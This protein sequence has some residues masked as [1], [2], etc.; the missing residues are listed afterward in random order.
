MMPITVILK[1]AMGGLLILLIASTGYVAV[2]RDDTNA[3]VAKEIR[4]NPNGERAQQIMLLTLADGRMYPV[5]FLSEDDRVFMGIDGRWW[6]EFVDEA[7][8]VQMFI[9]GENFS[10]YAR[11]VLDDPAYKADVFSR[12]RPT[13]P[14]WLPDFLN[15]KLVVITLED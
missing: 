10:G 15:G 14:K 3:R 2:T 6:R 4:A 8:P 7:Q 5:N 13:V 11:T 9:R 1:W 12:L